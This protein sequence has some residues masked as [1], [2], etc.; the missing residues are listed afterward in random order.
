VCKIRFRKQKKLFFVDS[1]KK[2]TELKS[3]IQISYGQGWQSIYCGDNPFF[4][5]EKAC[6]KKIKEL[7]EANKKGMIQIEK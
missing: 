7:R 5:S 2:N 1:S 6:D 3:C 4:D